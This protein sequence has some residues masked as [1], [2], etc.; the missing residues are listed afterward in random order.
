M[1]GWL[2]SA[3]AL[4]LV[5]CIGGVRDLDPGRSVPGDRA[6]DQAG[7][8]PD[9]GF[10]EHDAGFAGPDAGFADPDA[11]L[12]DPDAG[13]VDAETL[14]LCPTAQR[15]LVATTTAA[16]GLEADS[17]ARLGD[18]V[19]LTWT[20]YDAQWTPQSWLQVFDLA[21]H[22]LAAPRPIPPHGRVAALG[23][24]FVLGGEHGLERLD[25]A[26]QTLGPISARPFVPL[27]TVDGAVWGRVRTGS[28][29]QTV[30]ELLPTVG[31]VR[32][33]PLALPLDVGLAFGPGRLVV[34]APEPEGPR[35]TLYATDRAPPEVLAVHH[36]AGFEV[37]GEPWR[38]GALAAA[39]WWPGPG[40]FELLMELN[41]SSGRFVGARRYAV[42]EVD[43]R[44]GAPLGGRLQPVNHT[45]VPAAMVA[46]AREVALAWLD[47]YSQT[48]AMLVVEKGGRQ[49]R[50][51]L[52]GRKRSR[53]LMVEGPGGVLVLAP[54]H[55]P[56]ASSWENELRL[57]CLR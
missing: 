47:E 57:F 26:G 29:S 15:R 7:D 24:G 53:P 10:V 52:A 33:L 11:G 39:A 16:F 9:G 30:A 20:E 43:V 13:L 56:A 54:L 27:A 2:S 28:A 35:V 38:P 37:E 3:C 12:P 46:N 22:P 44:P 14:E 40:H 18:R 17:L 45:A 34:V 51:D 8:G 31:L 21:G 42:D 6:G 25:S 23:T 32:E 1:R 5:G 41:V 19:A 49:Q 50:I 4:L 55:T 48:G 36:L